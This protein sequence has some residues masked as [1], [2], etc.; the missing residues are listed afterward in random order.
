MILALGFHSLSF[1]SRIVCLTDSCQGQEWHNTVDLCDDPR[2]LKAEV[3][4]N[5]LP[6]PHLPTHD[7]LKTRRVLQHREFGNVYRAAIS[8]LRV[9][10][11]VMK[12]GVDPA[13][14]PDRW[15]APG[16]TDARADAEKDKKDRQDGEAKTTSNDDD[17]AH[18]AVSLPVDEAEEQVTEA[19]KQGPES[20]K[21]QPR[22]IACN[23][24]VSSPCWYCAACPGMSAMKRM[25]LLASVT[26]RL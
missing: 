18:A 23:Q 16:P 8:S 4:R 22:C 9:S 26:D 6:T 1:S 3:S 24:T 2:C 20:G 19:A 10:Q 13:D 14:V 25:F 17:K 12:G 7:I 15:N 21:Q 5:D 11:E